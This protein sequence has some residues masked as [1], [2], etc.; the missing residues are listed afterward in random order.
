KRHEGVYSKAFRS[1][2]STSPPLSI[3]LALLWPDPAIPLPSPS[4]SPAPPNS[5]PLHDALPI[6]WPAVRCV[7]DSRSEI[8]CSRAGRALWSKVGRL[9]VCGADTQDKLVSETLRFEMM[10]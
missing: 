4:S 9:Y 8:S 7:P 10:T 3:T 5:P 6:S 2:A 1:F